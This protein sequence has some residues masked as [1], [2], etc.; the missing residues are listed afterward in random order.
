MKHKDKIKYMKEWCAKNNLTLVLEGEVGFGRE[1]VGVLSE[2]CGAY[3]DYII[4]DNDY[5]VITGYEV[6]TPDDAYHKHPCV[7][8]LGRGE[9]AEAKL[10][11]WVNWFDKNNYSCKVTKVNTDGWDDID[12]MFKTGFNCCMTQHE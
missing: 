1:C 3:P 2:Q 7:A 4:F 5:N 12:F 11:E 9:D 6:W 10:Y 8:V